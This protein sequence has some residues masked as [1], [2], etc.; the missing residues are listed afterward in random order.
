MALEDRIAHSR[1]IPPRPR[2]IWVR[3]PRVE[4]RLREALE[5]PVVVVKAEPGYGKSTAVAQTLHHGPSP[6]LWYSLTEADRDPQRFL[7]HWI[8]AFR[9][10]DPRLGRSAAER[11]HEPGG[12]A[13]LDA[14]ANE[15]VDRLPREV[16]LVLDDY[17]LA[18]SPEIRALLERWLEQLPPAL[19][20]VLITR[21]DPEL[22]GAARARA[23]RELREMTP[24]A[25]AFAPERGGTGAVRRPEVPAE[26]KRPPASWPSEGPGRTWPPWPR[27]SWS[28]IPITRPLAGCWSRPGGP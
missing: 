11:L 17:H 22:R 21:R 26:P 25:L 20:L 13:A 4:A 14:L 19:R 2:P 10:L 9:S 5:A 8:Y 15:L 12:F 16:V 23:H 6:Y 27:P 3:R 18:D 28:G 24:S 1:L 7:A